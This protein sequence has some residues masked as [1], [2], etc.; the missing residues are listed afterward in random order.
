MIP[1]AGLGSLKVVIG[2]GAQTRDEIREVM[3]M[4]VFMLGW[5]FPPHISG[6]LG[7]ACFGLT[8]ALDE[9]GVRVS[10]VMPQAIP[11]EASSHVQFR[12]P[13]G[14][15]AKIAGQAKRVEEAFHNVEIQRVSAQFQAYATVTESASSASQKSSSAQTSFARPFRALG[16]ILAHRKAFAEGGTVGYGGNLMTQVR[17]YSDLAV[18][19]ADGE[20]F[21]V[22][23]A[24]DWMTYPAGLAVAAHTGKPLVVHVHSTEFDRSGERINQQV[25]DIERAG[26]YGADKV[27]CVSNFTRSILLGRYSAPAERVEVVYNGVNP[28]SNDCLAVPAVARDEKIVLFLGRITM[29]KGPEYFLQAAKKVLEKFNKVRFVMAGNG[30]LAA[31]SVEMAAELGIGRYVTF[32]GFLSSEDVNR[33]LR[34]ADLY[35]MPSVSEPFGIA[36]LEALCH[37]VPVIISKQA[38]VAE[39]LTNALKVDFWDIRQMADKMIAVLTRGPLKQVLGENGAAEVR[40]FKW[41]TAARRCVEIYESVASRGLRSA[42][43]GDSF[44]RDFDSAPAA[45]LSGVN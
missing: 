29:Q 18:E 3:K 13:L 33:L 11:L 16:N 9:L 43:S 27:I 10:F 45:V 23:H 42:G 30:D 2:A 22:I 34:M 31:R 38:G 21:D 6:G 35:V 7:T 19:L 32:T 40:N 36:P 24:H 15:A 39:V 28:P 8:K 26:I 12:N 4:R 44:Y 37:G 5:E 1:I 14:L 17:R 20:C 25:Y 41:A